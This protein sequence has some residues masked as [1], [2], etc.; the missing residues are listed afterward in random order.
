MKKVLLF[1]TL[2]VVANIVKA[3]DKL[4]R[5]LF[6][7][8]R[9]YSISLK[10]NPRTFY[11]DGNLVIQT[12][13]DAVSY[14]LENIKRFTYDSVFTGIDSPEEIGVTFSSDGETLTFTGLRPNTP[15]P[16]Y[17]VAGMLLHIFYSGS[18]NES[19]ISTSK[20]PVGVYVVKVY[21]GTYKLMKR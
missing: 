3:D 18:G 8:G 20:L 19:V 1:L 7:D 2:L 9:V 10:H 5:V 4:L 11:K 21:G 15:I 16:L 12:D 17:N 13:K 6:S 14:P